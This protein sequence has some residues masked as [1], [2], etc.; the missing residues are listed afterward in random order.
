MSGL[1]KVISKEELDNAAIICLAG[2][3]SDAELDKIHEQLKQVGVRNGTLLLSF[4][5][6]VD[7]SILTEEQMA[8]Y[9]WRL[10]E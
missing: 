3:C 9:G 6:R 7:M 5:D 8:V 4:T 2:H 1:I 10:I